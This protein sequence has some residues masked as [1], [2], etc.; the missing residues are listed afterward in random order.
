M[1]VIDCIDL[2][3]TFDDRTILESVTLT[4]R[5]GER[6]GLV[7]LNGCGKSTLGKILAGLE[8]DD[9]GTLSKRRGARIE[10]LDQE[11]SLPAGMTASEVVMTSLA[12]WND[13]KQRYDGST[14]AMGE[15]AE[16][17]EAQMERLIT[18]QA[19]AADEVERLG[20]WD[21]LHEVETVIGHLGLD[22]PNRLVDSMSGGERRRVALARLLV[23]H[24]D[25]AVL[26]EPTNHLDI[27]TIEWLEEYFTRSFPGA[28]LLITHDRYVLDR[29][30]TRT[31][32][33]H[34][35]VLDSY[36]GGYATYLEAK[37]ER[38]AH[39]DRSE[40]N[41]QNFL[42]RELEWLR[43][44][45]KA[46][47]TKQKARIGR[48][49]EAIDQTAPQ[50][51][52]TADLR[53]A[54]ERQGKT[55]LSI[56]DL[57][58]ER[59]G[60]VLIDGLDF[61]LAQ[62]ERIGVVG[63]NGTGKTSLF[64][65]LL[66]ELEPT[67]GTITLG[68]NTQLG[69]LDQGRDGL[70]DAATIREAVTGD[71]SHVEVG[72]ETL[73]VGAYLERFLF[74]HARQQQKVGVL[75]GGERARVCLARLLSQKSNLILL[76]EPTNDLDVATLGALEGML[77]DYGGS[78]LVISHDRWFLDRVAT[79]ILA[80]EGDGRVEL[81]RGN[82]SQYRARRRDASDA[83]G[84]S[85]GAKKS[86][87]GAAPA[88]RRKGG[89]APAAAGAK[90]RKLSFKE[91]HEL[92]GLLDL[93]DEAETRVAE[94]EAKLGDAATYADGGAS[95]ADLTR[96]LETGRAEVASLTQR[97]EN[98]EARREAWV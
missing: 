15:G 5:S 10:Y 48:A 78:A 28:L 65:A 87:P 18:T 91:R 6:V 75:S 23:S 3:K 69:Y 16:L 72:A 36:D 14:S 46:R 84:R 98:L 54:S 71:Q 52:R 70:D 68:S 4:I 30:T 20:G 31:L 89:H 24:P 60:H 17:D 7:G 79:S 63:P 9:G 81:H 61:D 53:L 76:D 94:I 37:A 38:E 26:D 45:P 25:L 82:Y 66:G 85:G 13:A 95:A 22:D 57:C 77:V 49:H 86:I 97:W 92:D 39:A 29:V 42:R 51:E 43:R 47:A 33:L 1:P 80:F 44:Q 74:T 62:G 55:I 96:S 88:P 90:P 35:G 56:S 50:K 27:A 19:E 73:S 58:I 59:G 12:E 40:R 93:I 11:P 67:G 8:A 34:D 2:H 41:R 32:E 21:R 83:P 64:L